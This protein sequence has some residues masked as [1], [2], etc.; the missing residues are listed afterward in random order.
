[1]HY[2][3]ADEDGYILVLLVNAYRAHGVSFRWVA[4]LL[5]ISPDFL[6]KKNR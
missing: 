1:M 2:M 3:I 6:S 5:K 4:S